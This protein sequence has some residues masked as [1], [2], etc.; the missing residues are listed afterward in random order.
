MPLHCSLVTEQGLQEKQKERKHLSPRLTAL[1]QSTTLLRKRVNKYL[2]KSSFANHL[3]ICPVIEL[4]DHMFCFVFETDSRSVARLECNGT[5]SAH[6]NLRL[7]GSSD[8]PA[9]VSQVAGTPGVRHHAQLIFVFFSRDGVSLCW[10]G[11]SRSLDLMIRPRRPPKV[12][13]LQAPTQQAEEGESLEPGRQRLQGAEIAPLHSSLGDRVRLRLKENKNKNTKTQR[14]EESE[15][16]ILFTVRKSHMGQ[17]RWLTPVIPALWE[18]EAGGSQGQEIE[19]ILV[20][21]E[22][23][24]GDSLEPG[25][26]RLQRAEIA[27]L[28]SNLDN[29]ARLHLKKEERKD[30]CQK[31]KQHLLECSGMISAHGSL[32]LP[33]PRDPP[34]SA[35]RVAG[36]TNMLHHAG[37]IFVFSVET[38]FHHVGQADLELLTSRA[39]PASTSRRTGITGVS[40]FVTQSCSVPRLECG[41]PISAHCDLRLPGS[42]DSPTSA[43]RVAGTTGA[44]HHARLSFAFLVETGFHC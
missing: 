26:R 12:L 34:A 24:A 38:G 5:I 36:I 33:G 30:S 3:G 32:R 37:L 44:R 39:P 10:P 2:F 25:R 21:M 19:T 18:A 15:Y 31:K 42:R 1:S 8:S 41:G 17:A 9:S 22:A 35:S 20:N 16:T 29:R 23:E 28:P 6:C 4:L 7:P 11:W 40:F 14:A 13:R 43:S 27:P